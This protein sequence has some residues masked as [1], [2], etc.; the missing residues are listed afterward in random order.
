MGAMFSGSQATTLDVSNFDTSKVTNMGSMFSNS[1][2]TTLD[3]SNFDTSNVTN[4]YGMF[5]GSKVTAL[6][7]N[8]FDTSKV[9]NM[10]QMFDGSQVT[11]LDLSSFDTSNVTNMSYMFQRANNLNTIYVSNKFNIDKV[12]QDSNM[13]YNCTNLVGGAGT[14]YG[15]TKIDKTYARID[16]GTSSPGYFTAK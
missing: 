4:M 5:F 12:T 6:D 16:G 10:T 1:Q 15:S 13:F 2:A 14:K 11:I 8:S 7:L 3:V 9:T